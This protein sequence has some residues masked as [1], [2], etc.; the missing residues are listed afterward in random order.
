MSLKNLPERLSELWH[1]I[2]ADIWRITDTEV[3]GFRQAGYNFLKTISLAIRRYE[4]DKL[5][6]QASA[7]TYSTLLSIIPLLAI[8]LAVANGFGFSNII[9]S[10]LFNYFPGQR[11]VL[12]EAFSFV[13]S[14]MVQIKSGVFVGIGIVL[15]LW[16][17]IS[18][19]SNIEGCFNK[20]WM[21]PKG[22][23]IYR[24]ITDYF[25]IILLIPVFMICSSG[26]SIFITTIF[27]TLSSY[28]LFTPLLEGILK[29]APFL[30]TILMFTG[31][32]IFIPNT[33][34]RFK[35]A[36]Y[37]GIFAGV[38][39]QIFQ[40][41]Y[42]SGQIWISKYNAI[43]GSFAALPLLL[44]WLQASWLICLL[45]AEI[46]YGS[47]NIQAYEFESDSKNI[48]RRYKDFLVLVI[49]SVIIKRFERGEKPCTAQKIAS[50]YK[51]PTRLVSEILFNLTELNLICEIADEEK[52]VIRFQPARDINKITVGNVLTLID[53]SGSENFKI[54]KE[55][56]LRKQWNTILESRTDMVMS[57]NE[58]LVKD[59]I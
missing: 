28:Q 41:I 16:T 21:V 9:Q 49:L 45:G 42:I 8:M 10:Q 51:I 20:I 53:Q 23:S 34:V 24:K 59:I 17:V 26:I 46:A 14:Y 29:V 33:K 35:N 2:T 48:T 55:L 37:A 32:Y 4:E 43:Y 38:V 12:Q 31:I 19:I 47:Q 40:Y 50:N 52:N 18:L 36:F 13:E 6:Q 1:F 11:D 5:Q 7:L 56:N 44:L 57:N 54:D 39:F 22:R 30:I 15:L 3:K 27:S 25:S 58:L